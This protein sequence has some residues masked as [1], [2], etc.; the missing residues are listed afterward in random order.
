MENGEQVIQR[1]VQQ[2]C[3]PF[4]VHLKILSWDVQI[5]PTEDNRFSYKVSSVQ[6]NNT[7]SVT[8]EGVKRHHQFLA[9]GGSVILSPIG[10]PGMT[11]GGNNNVN[12]LFKK[13]RN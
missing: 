3:L 4:K 10:T 11:M 2:V 7:F 5:L 13:R 12:E 1:K 6:V 9:F 8:L